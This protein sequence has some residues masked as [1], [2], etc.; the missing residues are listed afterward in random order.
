MPRPLKYGEKTKMYRKR[1][2]VS[3]IKEVSE[4]VNEKLKSY[5]VPSKK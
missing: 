4:L 2:P 1:V 3:K 5:A